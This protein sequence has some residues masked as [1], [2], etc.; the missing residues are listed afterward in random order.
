MKLI[1]SLILS[2]AAIAMIALPACRNNDNTSGSASA[3]DE[4][5]ALNDE[6]TLLRDS[7]NMARDY[8]N[9]L[10]SLVNEV[11]DGLNEIKEMEQIVSAPGFGDETTA[12]KE[13]L[14]NDILLIKNSVQNRLNRLAELEAKL[15]RAEATN[16]YNEQDKQS[17]LQTIA[18]LKQQLTDQ[19][20]MIDTLTS[21][22]DAAN[23]KIKTL[24][25]KVDSLN[26]VNTHVKNE[27]EKVQQ[28]KQRAKEEAVRIANEMNECFY[29]IGSKKELKNHKIIETGFL[30][31]TKV[32]QSSNI[33]QSYFTKADKRTLNEINLHSKKAKVLT[34]HDKQSYTID[35]AGGGMKVLRIHDPNRFWQYTNY[36]VVQVD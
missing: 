7:L 29:A 25:Q 14:R 16:K 21:Q 27:N 15:T 11:N 17:M 36:L 32:M 26:V 33:M 34:N 5:A 6:N 12:R 4:N 13:Q 20:R 23:T 19:Q 28:E 8:M 22:L 35:D 10:S 3:S 2:L 1:N 30:R 24:N 18:N 9:S 31:K